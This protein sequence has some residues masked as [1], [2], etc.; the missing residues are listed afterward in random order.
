[1]KWPIVIPMEDDLLHT[2]E[3]PYCDDPACPCHTAQAEHASATPREKVQ[4]KAKREYSRSRRR[5][6]RQRGL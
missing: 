3:N 6:K 1:M 2:Q 5:G 4:R